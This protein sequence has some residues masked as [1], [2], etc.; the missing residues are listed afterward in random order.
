MTVN[1]FRPAEPWLRKAAASKMPMMVYTVGPIVL[2]NFEVE[3]G[4]RCADDYLLKTVTK[5]YR[6]QVS[7]STTRPKGSTPK[8][9]VTE[10]DYMH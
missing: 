7:R 10:G 5:G 4:D 3:I 6:I 8:G 9:T 2:L 1:G